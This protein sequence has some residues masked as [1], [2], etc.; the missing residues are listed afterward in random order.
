MIYFSVPYSEGWTA[1]V[2]GEKCEIYNSAGMMAV[3]AE[4]GDNTVEFT[5]ETPGLKAGTVMGFLGAFLIMAE[6][7]F[8]RKR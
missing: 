1:T 4:K 5:Y 7:I 3:E 8:R 2:N 6:C